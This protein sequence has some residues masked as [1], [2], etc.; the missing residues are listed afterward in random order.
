MVRTIAMI[1]PFGGPHIF[2]WLGVAEHLSN[3]LKLGTAFI[4]K[5]IQ[6]IILSDRRIFPW[7]SWL[8]TVLSVLPGEASMLLCTPV[9]EKDPTMGRKVREYFRVCS[10]LNIRAS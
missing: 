1:M 5:C 4:N 9:I 8:I 6:N 3:V 7:H 10:A 2:S